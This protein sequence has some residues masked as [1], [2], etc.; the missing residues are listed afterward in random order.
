[1][2][3]FGIDVTPGHNVI[4]GVRLQPWEP[5]LFRPR[6]RVLRVL[7][8]SGQLEAETAALISAND[9]DDS[10]APRPVLDS[11]ASLPRD[12]SPVRAFS[13]RLSPWTD[14]LRHRR[15]LRGGAT[16]AVSA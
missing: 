2:T 3:Q 7:G 15:R 13:C 6:A 10:A 11:L 9:V 8:E 12:I 5:Q 14:S 4:V 1:M 16:F